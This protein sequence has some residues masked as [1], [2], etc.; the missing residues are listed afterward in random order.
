MLW[1]DNRLLS[2]Y[3]FAHLLK[4]VNFQNAV[5]TLKTYLE[6]PD[7]AADAQGAYPLVLD[8]TLEISIAPGKEEGRL[9]LWGFVA[10]PPSKPVDAEK[11]LKQMLKTSLA[12]SKLEAE[13]LLLDEAHSTIMLYKPLDIRL[14]EDAALYEAFEAFVVSLETW[15]KIA[16][17]NL[18][19]SSFQPTFPLYP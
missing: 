2:A 16:E 8:N 5:D 17:D 7:L 6:L 11:F 1:V 3:P 4:I 12:R 9:C 18:Q 19:N 10:D 14:I 13:Y 15:Q